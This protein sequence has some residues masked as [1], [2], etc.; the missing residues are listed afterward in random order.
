M[1][2]SSSH[3]H[4]FLQFVLFATLPVRLFYVI[5]ILKVFP[6]F[7]LAGLL[8]PT[9]VDARCKVLFYY[10][11]KITLSFLYPINRCRDN[12][13]RQF[14]RD[15][16]AWLYDDAFKNGRIRTD[17]DICPEPEGHRRLLTEAR[18]ALGDTEEQQPTHLE[19]SYDAASELALEDNTTMSD[20]LINLILETMEMEEAAG[21][22]ED[23]EE[24]EKEE[25]EAEEEEESVTISQLDS[26][27]V[28]GHQNLKEEFV[29]RGE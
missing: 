1:N 26:E 8:S 20:E 24:E 19:D 12:E 14:G 5:M 15:L 3:L 22:E 10:R 16:D 9:A 21:S 25:V 29:F 7:L 6:F 2:S 18:P 13:I 4:K 27:R 17:T 11:T 28:L 23:E